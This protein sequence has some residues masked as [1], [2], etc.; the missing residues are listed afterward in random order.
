MVVHWIRGSADREV[1]QAKSRSAGWRWRAS[2]NA[3]GAI[4]TGITTVVF[5]FS[6]FVAGAWIVVVAIPI[7]MFIFVRIHRYYTIVGNELFAGGALPKPQPDGKMLVVVPI[8]GITQ[9]T[10][11]TISQAMTMGGEIVAVHVAFSDDQQDAA[12]ITEKWKGWDPGV[13]LVMLNTRYHSVVR[14]ITRYVLQ[15]GKEGRDVVV[16]IGEMEPKLLRHRILHN[17]MGAVLSIYLRR[18]TNA[19]VAVLPMHVND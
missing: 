4:V 17:Q 1:G 8:T 2:L 18:H 14:P 13:P 5:I 12:R 19:T 10:R 3:L 16:L 7:I 6:K 9:L 15:A 11:S